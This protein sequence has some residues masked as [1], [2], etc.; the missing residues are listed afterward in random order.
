[1]FGVV[2]GS[3]QPKAPTESQF[4]SSTVT[5]RMFG[6]S[7]A[8]LAGCE[9]QHPNSPSVA[10]IISFMVSLQQFKMAVT[11]PTAPVA[12]QRTHAFCG[13]LSALQ[14]DW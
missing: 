11:Q 4:M 8:A 9:S 3:L 2:P 6:R 7:T 5:I 10:V 12:W 1:M 14:P 13:C